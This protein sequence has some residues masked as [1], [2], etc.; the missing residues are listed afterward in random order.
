VLRY[1]HWSSCSRRADSEETRTIITLT[2]APEGDAETVLGVQHDN[3]T[4]EDTFGHAR[5]FWRRRDIDSL[6]AARVPGWG[7][8]PAVWCS[9][10][11]AAGHSG[12]EPWSA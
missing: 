2:L 6:V 8:V 9:R 11:F 3:L 1:N 10:G 12:K 7:G 4:G 5:F